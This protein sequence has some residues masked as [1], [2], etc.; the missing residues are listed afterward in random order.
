T[1]NGGR[2]SRRTHDVLK[3]T[4][5]EGADVFDGGRE[6]T[7][8]GF[9]AVESNVRGDNHVVAIQKRV[10]EKQHSEL[11]LGERLLEDLPFVLEQLFALQYIERRPRENPFVERLSERR[12]VHQ[13][14]ARRVHQQRAALDLS[15][16]FEVQQVVRLG[17]VRAVK[18]NDVG[19][20][21]QLVERNV[22]EIQH[23]GE[24]RLA[25]EVVGDHLHPE[26]LGDLDGVQANPPRAHDAQGFSRQ[27]KT[28]QRLERDVARQSVDKSFVDVS[29]QGQDQREGVFGDGVLAV[30][31]DICHGDAALAAEGQINV[32]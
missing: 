9:A 6:D 23:L 21:Q 29:R 10:V 17:R 25:P 27:I 18:R 12:W 26:A 28:A 15:D 1:G 24:Q 20:A 22:A 16:V 32:V 30:R 19:G 2:P 3:G 4:G 11:V 7:L 13:P 5:Q 8:D 31:G 14:Y